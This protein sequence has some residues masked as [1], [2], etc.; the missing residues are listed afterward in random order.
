MKRAV[1]TGLAGAAILCAATGVPAGPAIDPD[2][3]ACLSHTTSICLA[4]IMYSMDNGKAWPPAAGFRRAILPYLRDPRSFVCPARPAAGEGITFNAALS[5]IKTARLKFP[6]QT[7]LTY[8]SLD[9]RPVYPHGRRAAIGFA[10]GHTRLLTREEAAR[11]IWK[12]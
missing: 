1:L 2:A 11:C 8:E 3:K 4:A 9:R 5:R 12:P 6:G 7:V 10:D